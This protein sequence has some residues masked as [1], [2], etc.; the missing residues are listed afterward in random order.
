MDEAKLNEKIEILENSYSKLHTLESAQ[1]FE[2]I[3]K[4]I[5]EHVEFEDKGNDSTDCVITVL[6]VIADLV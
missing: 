2:E 1:L 4:A 5:S 6:S 3:T